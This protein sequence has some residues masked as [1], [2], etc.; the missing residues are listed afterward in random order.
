ML[1]DH[2]L[3]LFFCMH[4]TNK[5]LGIRAGTY[6]VHDNTGSKKL[7]RKINLIVIW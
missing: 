4:I 7:P 6:Y 3:D 2:T 1:A 5:T